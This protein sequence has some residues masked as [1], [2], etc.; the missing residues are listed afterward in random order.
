MGNDLL[1]QGKGDAVD[2]ASKQGD[3]AQQALLKLQ[4]EFAD[5]QKEMVALKKRD[6]ELNKEVIGLEKAFDHYFAP[7]GQHIETTGDGVCVLGGKTKWLG[8]TRMIVENGQVTKVEYPNGKTREFKYENGKL[9][10]YKA[11]DGSLWKTKDGLHWQRPD[12]GTRIV[13]LMKVDKENGSFA[14]LNLNPTKKGEQPHLTL[15]DTDGSKRINTTGPIFE[16]YL[17]EMIESVYDKLPRNWFTGKLDRNGLM[18]VIN[19]SNRSGEAKVAAGIL[20]EFI[21][22]DPNRNEVGRADI[23]RAKQGVN[24]KDVLEMINLMIYYSDPVPAIEAK[25]AKSKP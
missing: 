8:D 17:G 16:Q 20:L 25:P 4:T 24:F 5:L 21:K 14:F 2:P 6:E 13:G 23:D 3:P 7:Y 15:V 10:E 9:S 19:D 11:E 12:S 18:D 22:R 1:I